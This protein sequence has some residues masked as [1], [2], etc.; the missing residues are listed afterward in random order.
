MLDAPG[1]PTTGLLAVPAHLVG[2]RP[3]GNGGVSR[4]CLYHSRAELKP[5]WLPGFYCAETPCVAQEPCGEAH[6]FCPGAAAGGGSF[7]ST[8]PFL[9]R[10][11]SPRIVLCV[12]KSRQQDPLE[13]VGYNFIYVIEFPFN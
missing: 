13:G 8:P 12:I 6:Y 2:G 11:T 9:L 10:D 3:G 5:C 1:E 7:Q 4:T